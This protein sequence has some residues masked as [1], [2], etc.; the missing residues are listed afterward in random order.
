MVERRSRRF[1]SH[2]AVSAGM[3]WL[4]CVDIF[5]DAR[6]AM[7][8]CYILPMFLYIFYGRLSWPNG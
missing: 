6:S 3:D 4:Q 2:N 5:M 1:S 7:R 8:P